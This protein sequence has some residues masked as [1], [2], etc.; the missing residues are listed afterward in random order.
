M[1]FTFLRIEARAAQNDQHS[2]MRGTAKAAYGELLALEIT[3]RT[4]LRSCHQKIGIVS[5]NA[6]HDLCLCPSDDSADAA[7]DGGDVINAP[8]NQRCHHDVG[9]GANEFSF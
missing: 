5:S 8:A 3:D 9:S 1:M 7:G 6:S 4:D 2:L